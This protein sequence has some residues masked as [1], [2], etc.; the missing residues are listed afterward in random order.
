MNAPVG[1]GTITEPVSTYTPP[2]AASD[3]S[4]KSNDFTAFPNPSYDLLAI[5]SKAIVTY[6]LQVNL[7][8][9]TGRLI[10]QKT[11]HQGTTLCYFDTSSLY[12]GV[13]LVQIKTEKDQFT[14]KVIIRK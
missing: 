4:I 7:L 13:Y 1:G 2:L 12:N 3:F 6:D 10:D 11:I 8:D 9:D 5:Q 14:L